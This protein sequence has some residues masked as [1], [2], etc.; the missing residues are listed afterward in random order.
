M[1]EVRLDFYRYFKWTLVYLSYD[2]TSIMLCL[3]SKL[4]VCFLFFYVRCIG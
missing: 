2:E 1:F 4:N 3:N